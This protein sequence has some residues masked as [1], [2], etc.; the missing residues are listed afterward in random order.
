MTVNG[1]AFVLVRALAVWLAV[2]AL[3]NVSLLF[4]NW[5][6]QAAVRSTQQ[7]AVGVSVILPLATAALVWLTADWLSAKLVGP[8]PLPSLGAEPETVVRAVIGLLGL[9]TLAQSVPDLAWYA[10]LYAAINAT[11]ETVLGPVGTSPDLRAQFWD[12]TGKANLASVVARAIV[13]IALMANATSLAQTVL[14]RRSVDLDD[15]PTEREA[16]SDL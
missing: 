9:L 12:V 2:G 14:K 11:R 16:G 5:H 10:A 4:Q 8:E 15:E 6:E 7:L 13:G 1:L 3:N